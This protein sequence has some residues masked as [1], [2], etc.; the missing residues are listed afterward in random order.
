MG[1]NATTE[2]GGAVEVAVGDGFHV[3]VGEDVGAAF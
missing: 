3:V 2:V 1:S